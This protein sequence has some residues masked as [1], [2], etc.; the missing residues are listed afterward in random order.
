MGALAVPAVAGA[1][2]LTAVGRAIAVYDPSLAP[3]PAAGAVA[4]T[5]DR[6]RFARRLFESRPALVIG[7]SRRAD[8]LLIE[9]V[10]RE[11][12]YVPISQS[13]D[14]RFGWAMAPRS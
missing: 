12:G 6:I 13:L 11:A 2:K 3:A 8:T 7:L 10:G 5:G 4:I 14:A 9:E 1:S